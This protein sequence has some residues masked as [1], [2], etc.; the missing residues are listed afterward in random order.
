MIKVYK[1]L[2]S[3][4][5]IVLFRI[6]AASV[7]LVAASAAS[8]ILTWLPS[9]A[10]LVCFI[11]PYIIISYDVI[12]DAVHN[13][14]HGEIF[15][16]NFLML[17]A[18]VGAFVLGDYTEG[19]AVMLFFQVGELF[20]SYA[21]G[22]ARRSVAELMDIRPDTASVIRDGNE[23]SVDPCEVAVGEIIVIRPGERIP[24]D[25][26]VVNGASSVDTSAL[27][28]EA[29]PRDVS[30]GDEIISGCVNISGVIRAEIKAASE[31]STVSRILEM[32]ENASSK[33]AK[34]EKFITKFAHLYTPVVVG[35]AALLALVPPL[36]TGNPF[37]VWVERALIFLVISCPCALVISI[38]LS[39]FGAVGGASKHG[40]L[41]KGGNYLEA[42][43]DTSVVVF[44]KTGTL[45]T[46]RFEVSDVHAVSCDKA[47]LLEYAAAAEYNSPHPIARS[48]SE[49]N[50]RQIDASLIDGIAD[51]PGQG[52]RAVYR[53]HEI[54]AGSVGLMKR[55]G[56]PLDSVVTDN[57]VVH[58]AYD[59]KYLG[60]I[61][62]TDTVKPTS[63]QAVMKLRSLGITD[64]V[65]LTGDRRAVG[66]RTA[67]L[68]GIDRAVCEL[69]PQD[70]V[71][72][73]EKLLESKSVGKTLT[74][75][76]DGVNDAPVLTRADAGI[77][78]GA[79]G[80]DAAIEAADIV[81]MDDDPMKLYDAVK[82]ARRTRVIVRQNI[83]FALTVKIGFLLL[84]ALGL[85]NMWLA[86]FAD[87]G[88]A[89]IAILNAMRTARYKSE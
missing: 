5:R 14:L 67:E 32:V 70:K 89:V 52:V 69:L 58:V 57:T 2:T 1:N 62:V 34:A 55:Y 21:V 87:V 24:L 53:G 45:T 48:I 42:L 15:D 83:V 3:S 29:L 85:S 40:I 72:E 35:C 12:I 36:V 33:K 26:V 16:E 8:N 39:F 63:K 10:V 76:G 38:P 59:R 30:V 80:S 50:V 22:S 88:V 7:L 49:A 82:I 44:D 68:L 75:V 77:A 64:T 9:A 60:Y 66:E 73:V 74:Y 28:G 56:V 86:V 54:C 65:M 78:M 71:S 20:Q 27:T 84:A 37:A 23:S 4:Q 17:I 25:A 11:V 18:T 41:I 31:E 51:H 47:T 79:L 19:C 6:L 13:I 61:V 81:L 46:G 43:A